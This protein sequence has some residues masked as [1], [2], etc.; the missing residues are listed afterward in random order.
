MKPKGAGES[1]A[2][3]IQRRIQGAANSSNNDSLNKWQELSAN[4]DE[5]HL[6]AKNTLKE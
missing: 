3:K 5:E 4:Y 2:N 6:V 1:M